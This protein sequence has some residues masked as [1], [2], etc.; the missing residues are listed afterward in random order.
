[1]VP[2]VIGMSL[3]AD[4]GRMATKPYACPFTSLY[5]DVLARHRPRSARNHR[6]AQQ[7]RGLERLSDLAETRRRARDVLEQ[8]DRGEL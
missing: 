7:V 1:M 4:G 2:N 8:L 5:W 6:M 3:H